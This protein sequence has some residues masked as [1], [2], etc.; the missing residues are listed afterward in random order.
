MSRQLY[1]LEALRKLRDERA[2][3]QALS[4]AAQIARSNEAEAKL[5]ARE[6]ARRDHETRSIETLRAE[7][8]RLAEG[9]SRGADLL[10]L[11]EFETAARA[12][13]AVLEQTEES[14]RQRLDEE[15][16]QEQNLREMLARLEAEAK[17]VRHHEASFHERHAERQEK[18]EE[19]AALE[20]W[21]AR[22]H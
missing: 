22:R 14:A 8:Q 20:Q 18:A 16:T 9:G 2:E 11:A 7:R 13:A 1:P 6:R 15:R 19:E 3:G 4:L 12:Q 10:R 5:R 17:L 21:S